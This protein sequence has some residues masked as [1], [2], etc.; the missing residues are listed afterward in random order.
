MRNG[1]PDFILIAALG[2][3]TLLGGCGYLRQSQDTFVMDDA[4]RVTK[5]QI[6]NPDAGRNPRVVAGLDAAVAKNVNES[7]QKSFVKADAGQQRAAMTFLGLQGIGD[8]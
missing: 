7:Y 1:R 5:S 4:P 2:C 3:V 6:L 8:Q